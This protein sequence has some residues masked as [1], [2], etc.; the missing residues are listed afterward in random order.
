MKDPDHNAKQIAIPMTTITS[1]NPSCLQALVDNGLVLA[2]ARSQTKQALVSYLSEP[3]VQ[4]RVRCVSKPGWHDYS[5][6]LPH[7]TFQSSTSTD[8]KTVL[9]AENKEQ[10]VQQHGNIGNTDRMAGPTSGATCLV[11]AVSCSASAQALPR[12]CST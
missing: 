6:V 11:I 9:Q 8:E 12:L 10:Q 1:S 5:F 4:A 7:R 3:S 2:D